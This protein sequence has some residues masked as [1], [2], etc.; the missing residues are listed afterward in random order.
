MTAPIGFHGDLEQNGSTGEGARERPHQGA[1][2]S[3]AGVPS[4]RTRDRR[5]STRRLGGRPV[6]NKCETCQQ[7]L[8]AQEAIQCSG[9]NKGTHVECQS[10]LDIGDRVHAESRSFRTGVRTGGFGPSL[11]QQRIN[12]VWLTQVVG[13]EM[14]FRIFW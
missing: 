8:P 7:I 10:Q 4:R 13:L 11:R 9:C 5:A 14:N 1:R 2:G 12:K 3:S 6:V